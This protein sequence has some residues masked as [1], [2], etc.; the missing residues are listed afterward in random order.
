M[1][2]PRFF[3]SIIKNH[4]GTFIK[5]S[6]TQNNYL[7]VDF[8]AMI[9]DTIKLIPTSTENYSLATYENKI[10]LETIRYLDLIIAFVNPDKLTYVCMDGVP[11]VAKMKQQR[12]RRYKSLK[13]ESFK[14]SLENKL[15]IKSSEKN[16]L[17]NWS[18]N[19]ISPGTIFMEKLSKSIKM[20]YKNNTNVVINDYTKCGEGEHKIMKFIKD[21]LEEN[22]TDNIV[23]YSPDADLIVLCLTTKKNKIFLLRN[24]DDPDIRTEHQDKEYG[25]LDIDLCREYFTQETGNLLDYS[26]LTFL[27]GNDFV[28]SSLFLKVKDN[29]LDTIIECYNK[30]LQKNP[31]TDSKWTLVN[32]ENYRINDIF[33]KELIRELRDIELYKLKGVQIKINKVR[34]FEKNTTVS[35]EELNNTLLKNFQHLDYYNPNHPLFDNFNKIFNIINYF[36]DDWKDRYNK[37]FFESIN[38][39]II[40]NVCHEYIKSLNFCLKYYYTND[41]DWLFYYKYRASPT[42]HDLYEYLEK[43]SIENILQNSN[44]L[45]NEPI[46]M[47]EQLLIILPKK[48]LHLVP[49]EYRGLDDFSVKK[50]NKKYYPDTFMLDIMHGH[51]YIY[52]ERICN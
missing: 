18:T 38:K 7:F 5:S 35:Q 41:V 6:G 10:I 50:I 20:H 29:G 52:S 4:A 3:S 13:Y 26:F 31:S 48:S 8:N 36:R 22:T 30:V 16:S 1:G 46:S 14:N 2:I 9:Y 21:N 39:D 44:T 43:N 11:P 17:K 15:S 40:D 47:Y 32:P 51:K 19:C 34:S 49:K 37:F 42:F 45:K 28:V 23:I 27:C 12:A 33:F 25:F 24:S